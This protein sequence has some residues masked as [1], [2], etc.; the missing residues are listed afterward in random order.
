MNRRIFLGRLLKGAGVTLLGFVPG[1]FFSRKKLFAQAESFQNVFSRTTKSNVYDIL[2]A[3]TLP[4]EQKL[5]ILAVREL[6]R[7]EVTRLIELW[8]K[9]DP[10]PTPGDGCGANCGNGCGNNCSSQ[11]RGV[12]GVFNKGGKLKVNF[13]SVS[14]NVL[15]S[16]LQQVL[17]F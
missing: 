7:D 17:N 6:G 1:T 2:K 8:G 9:G 4:G 12:I 16:A 10:N 11:I 5:A 15:K 13:S 3:S 14:R